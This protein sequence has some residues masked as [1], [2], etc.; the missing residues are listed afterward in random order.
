MDKYLLKLYITGQTIRSQRAI[1]NL[2]KII[3]EELDDKY[4]MK[5]IDILEHPKLAEDE[6]ILATPLLMKKLPLPIRRIIGDLSDSEKVL[7]GLD[8]QTIDIKNKEDN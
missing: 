1:K 8:L 4:E 7:M 6:K 3:E 2:E 5:V